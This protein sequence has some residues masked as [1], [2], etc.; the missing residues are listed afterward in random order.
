MASSVCSARFLGA[1]GLD[2]RVGVDVGVVGV[3]LLGVGRGETC[4]GP[5]LDVLQLLAGGIG[6][7][8]GL[9]E[10]PAITS[11]ASAVPATTTFI[12]TTMAAVL[13]WTR[14]RPALPARITRADSGSPCTW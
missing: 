1:G 4:G 10:H 9:D 3:G 2:G 6:V 8:D 5:E 14:G 12:T 7:A 11:A 13:G